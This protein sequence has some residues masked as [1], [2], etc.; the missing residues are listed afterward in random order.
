[1]DGHSHWNKLERK[2]VSHLYGRSR[3]AHNSLSDFNPFHKDEE[4]PRR[5]VRGG[6]WTSSAFY[7]GVAAR[8]TQH[9]NQP[10]ATVGFR[11][12][13]EVSAMEQDFAV[14]NGP[15]EEP[16]PLSSGGGNQ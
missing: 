14:P 10:S 15:T 11:C 16:P 13:R 12:V 6:S 8:D 9:M 7:I 4:E 3:T 5:I 2:G 1:M